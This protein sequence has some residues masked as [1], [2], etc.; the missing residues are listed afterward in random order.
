MAKRVAAGAGPG[1]EEFIFDEGEDNLDVPAFI[2]KNSGLGRNRARETENRRSCVRERLY[3]GVSE[4]NAP[5]GTS[6]DGL[7]TLRWPCP[8]AKRPWPFSTLGWQAVYRMLAE[9]PGLAP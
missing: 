4:P 8:G 3:H 9:E 1:E 5:P 6:E 2:R 7:P